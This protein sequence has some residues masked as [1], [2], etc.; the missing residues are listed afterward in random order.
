MLA[1]AALSDEPVLPPERSLRDDIILAE[2]S[3]SDD[4][5]SMNPMSLLL[6]M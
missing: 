2:D 4:A 3:K 1:D 5:D 6:R